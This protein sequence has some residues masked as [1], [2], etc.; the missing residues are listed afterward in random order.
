MRSRVVSGLPVAVASLVSSSDGTFGG[1]GGGGEPSSTSMI[2][3]PRCT[4]EVR[5]A[6]DV[7]ISMLPCPRIPRRFG[8]VSDTRWNSLPTMLGMS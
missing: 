5:S 4:G 2:H 6:T 8:S 3:L 1:G 7:L